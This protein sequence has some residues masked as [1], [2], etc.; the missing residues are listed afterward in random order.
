MQRRK[1]YAVNWP[2]AIIRQIVRGLPAPEYLTQR[3]SQGCQVVCS[4]ITKFCDNEHVNNEVPVLQTAIFLGL[5]PPRS[6]VPCRG[7]FRL[8]VTENEIMSDSYDLAHREKIEKMKRPKCI[9]K[10]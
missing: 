9:Y 2:S 7:C 5:R 6:G 1:R 4:Q 10:G 8:T 3:A